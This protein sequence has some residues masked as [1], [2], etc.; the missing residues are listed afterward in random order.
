MS[1]QVSCKFEDGLVKNEL[2]QYLDYNKTMGKKIGAQEQV[3]SRCLIQSS[4]EIVLIRE[5][6]LAFVT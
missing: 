5:F 2:R 3:A 1:V 6:I 4:P